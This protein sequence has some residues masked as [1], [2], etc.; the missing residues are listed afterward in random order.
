MACTHFITL[1]RA[2]SRDREK[3]ASSLKEQSSN[4]LTTSPSPSYLHRM[5]PFC[6][7]RTRHSSIDGVWLHQKVIFLP[8]HVSRARVRIRTVQFYIR[9]IIRHIQTHSHTLAAHSHKYVICIICTNI[10]ELRELFVWCV[11]CVLNSFSTTTFQWRWR[12]TEW[13]VFCHCRD[14]TMNRK[15]NVVIWW[16][17][18]TRTWWNTHTHTRT[19]I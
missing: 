3:I 8:L 18:D 14:K 4:T 19:H 17:I 6:A 5:V 10:Y 15:K 11:F 1:A 12:D 7:S 9:C 16:T 2:R 13:D